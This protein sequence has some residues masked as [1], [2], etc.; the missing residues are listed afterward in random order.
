[1][2][3]IVLQLLLF[4]VDLFNLAAL[5][6]YFQYLFALFVILAF[7]LIDITSLSIIQMTEQSNQIFQSPTK[8]MIH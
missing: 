3:A 7:R 5:I 1:M 4:N 2:W 8:S 6:N